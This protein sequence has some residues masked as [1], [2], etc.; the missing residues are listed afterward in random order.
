MT[1]RSD[2]GFLTMVCN[3]RAPLTVAINERNPLIMHEG[4]SLEMMKTMSAAEQLAHLAARS[5]PIRSVRPVGAYSSDS[6]L[7]SP[8]HGLH[9]RPRKKERKKG[10]AYGVVCCLN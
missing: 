9:P 8:V 1:S 7:L 5:Q 3:L 10:N 6:A 2:G 4:N